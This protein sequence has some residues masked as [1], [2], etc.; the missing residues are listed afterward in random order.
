MCRL[1]FFETKLILLSVLAIIWPRFVQ[2]LS[3]DEQLKLALSASLDDIYERNLREALKA[4]SSSNYGATSH[5]NEVDDNDDLVKTMIEMTRPL[6]KFLFEIPQEV[7]GSSSEAEFIAE[8][9][10]LFENRLPFHRGESESSSS[11]SPPKTDI[12]LNPPVKNR[13]PSYRGES[14]R[15]RPKANSN[16]GPPD[17]E[18]AKQ[19]YNPEKPEVFVRSLFILM[20]ELRTR[21]ESFIPHFELLLKDKLGYHP[22][23]GRFRASNDFEPTPVCTKETLV[24][25]IE[26]LKNQQKLPP[27]HWHPGL[28]EATKDHAV[29]IATNWHS[30]GQKGGPRSVKMGSDGK[31]VSR[32]KLLVHIPDLPEFIAISP[33]TVSHTGFTPLAALLGIILDDNFNFRKNVFVAW[34]R[35]VSIHR[36]RLRSNNY[37]FVTVCT[38]LRKS[39]LVC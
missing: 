11:R 34:F 18:Y 32:D 1:K 2:S 37:A 17:E 30:I 29:D 26:F 13:P 20:N 4:S 5:D 10:S 6:H 3:E 12:N 25:F 22:K 36:E 19:P 14:S 35:Y 38:F 27:L 7:Y 8:Q 33:Q 23:T 28:L 15:S 9:Q 21:P 39:S 31:G 16:L 24:Q